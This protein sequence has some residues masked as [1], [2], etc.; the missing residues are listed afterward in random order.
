M[1]QEQLV[2]VEL[3]ETLMREAQTDTALVQDWE[4]TLDE[5]V[6]SEREALVACL[7]FNMLTEV[8]IVKNSNRNK[9]DDVS[10]INRQ[11]MLDDLSY[12]DIYLTGW[13][14]AQK[15]YYKYKF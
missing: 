2:N 12:L 5:V 11:L 10:D 9:D 14:A 6:Q 4:E 7:I 3:T 15:L 8:I 1:K 13:R